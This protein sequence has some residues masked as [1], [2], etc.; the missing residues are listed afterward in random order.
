MVNLQFIYE[1][2]TKKLGLANVSKE[3]KEM[4]KARL[5]ICVV[6]PNAQEQWLSKFIDDMLQRDELDSG[7]GCKLCTCPINAKA[8]VVEEKCPDKPPRW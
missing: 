1:G 8:L 5:A 4:A 7:I 2:W 3:N 6:C